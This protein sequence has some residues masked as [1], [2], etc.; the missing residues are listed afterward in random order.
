[1]KK[2]LCLIFVL[3]LIS[4]FSSPVFAAQSDWEEQLESIYQEQ[5]EASGA[6]ELSDSLP[7]E[8]R[9]E[10]SQL[11]VENANWDEIKN[12]TPQDIF[13]RIAQMAQEK[14]YSPIKAAVSV[15]AVMLL[16]A[17]LNGLR[18]S[19]GERPL[20]GIIGMVGVLCV[21]SAV[22]NP[23]VQCIGNATS[24][25][26]GAAGF[27]LACV[28]VLVGIMVTAGQ[29]VSAG[30]YSLMMTAAGN[31]ISILSAQVLTPFLNIFLAFSI[32]SAV[33]PTLHLSGLCNL[34]NKTVKWLLGFCMTIF[35][36]SAYLAKHRFYSGR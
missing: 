20:A 9:E 36:Q 33:S 28:P 22:V 21:C 8:T 13:G 30:S 7:Q 11:G 25:I 10:L 3:G 14:G 12:I 29:A 16:C 2:F 6:K 23:V 35:Y 1:M 15:L 34:F 24:V 19:F 26:E 17:L 5:W 27:M 4:F 18:L 32:V 31:T